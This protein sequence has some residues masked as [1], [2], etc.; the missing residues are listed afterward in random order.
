MTLFYSR[1]VYLK[2]ILK[3][4]SDVI[5]T[6]ATKN[7]LVVIYSFIDY[8]EKYKLCVKRQKTS[9]KRGDKSQRETEEKKN[10]EML[11]IS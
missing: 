11:L 1:F 8:T 3:Y 5:V 10:S 2:C 4:Y 6:F 9:D 7:Y